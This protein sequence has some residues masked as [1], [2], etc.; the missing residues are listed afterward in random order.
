MNKKIRFL[1]LLIF[2]RVSLEALEIAIEHA[3]LRAFGKKIELNAQ[4]IQLS[5]ASQS[6][7][8]VVGGRVE[9]YYVRTGEHVKRGQK[10]VLL[11]SIK[12]S[13]MTAEF[14]SLK[15]QFSAQELNFNASSE[16]YEK[17][18]TSMSALNAQSIKKD[19]LSAKL[20]ALNSQL[21]TLGINTQTLAKASSNFILYA[22]S[23]GIVSAILQPLH[24]SLQDDTPIISLVKNEVYYLKSFLPLKYA[25]RVKIGQKIVL[26]DG[27]KNIV[28]HITQ[29]L[30]TIDVNTQR[31]VLL[32]SIDEKTSNLYINAYA[33]AT[34]YFEASSKY[35]SIPKSALS[36]FNNEWVVFMAKEEHEDEHDEHDGHEEEE[37]LPYEARVVKI[38]ESDE[39]Y[40][41]VK[42][43]EVGEE[44]VS[45]KPYYV[46]SMMLKS[47]L[48]GHGH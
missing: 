14:L 19:E 31:I 4:I 22:H 18:M 44:Y 7:M 5:N 39:K 25:S 9:K 16:L 30:P 42:G 8:S 20:T 27:E 13:K 41:G 28:S 21:S 23:D 26:K 35:V 1:T 17:G 11:Q 46:K 15:K 10:I 37:E 6:I 45:D 2:L 34:L 38:I 32:S 29:V 36:F 12:L 33:K 24:T 40:V 43:I 3:K 48:G 47:S